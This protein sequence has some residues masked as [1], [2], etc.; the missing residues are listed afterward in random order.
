V[1]DVRLLV[2]TT[3]RNKLREIR[4]I[5]AGLDVDVEGLDAYPPIDEPEETGATFEEN[6]RQ[7]AAYYSTRLGVPAVAEDSGL[8]IDGLGGEPGVHSARYGGA[9]ADTYDRKFEIVYSRLRERN[10]L[11]SAARFV[12]ALALA[13]GARILFEAR[14]TIE[15]VIADGPHGDGGFGYDPIF[16]SPPHGRTLAQLTEAEKA[17]V[18]HRGRA[19]RQFREALLAKP[20]LLR[21]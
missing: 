18:S 16:F 13:D 21:R 15:G 10:A 7:K 20:G 2:A 8:V 3:N 17:V 5:M 11:G 1:R 4:G 6:A 14:G 12:C 19:F 9:D